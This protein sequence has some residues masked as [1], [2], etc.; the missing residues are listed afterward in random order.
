MS[1]KP[2][3]TPAADAPLQTWLRYLEQLHNKDIDLGLERVQRVCQAAGLQQPA[4]FVITVAGTN[5]KGSTVCYLSTILRNAGYRVGVYT[6]PHLERYNERVQINGEELSDAQHSQAFAAVEAVRGDTSLS[7]FEFGTLAAFWLMKQQPLDVAILEVGLG[8]RLDAVNTV[9]A[10]VAIVTSI[11]VD[12]IQFLGD[13]REL[14]GREKAGV[15]RPSKPLICGDPQPPKSIADSAASI[16]AKLYQVGQDFSFSVTPK[17][18]SYRGVESNLLELPLPQL[19]L[20]NAATAIAALEQLPLAVSADAI[21]Q[22]LQAA[23]LEGRMQQASYQNQSILLD[24]A[25]NEHAARYLAKQLH[26][27]YKNRPVYAVVGMLSDK[28][29]NAVFSTLKSQI[30]EWF[31]GSLSEPRGSQAEQLAAATALQEQSVTTFKSVEEAFRAALQRA[32][33][34]DSEKPL[35]FVFGSFYT[36]GR[37]NQLIRS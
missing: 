5:G 7:Y 33:K 26:S 17:G 35:V 18:W 19:P 32:Q 11:G 24:V 36:V 1:D 9:D 6:S 20:M 23:Q 8:G 25:H 31:L 4:R 22:G 10:D 15:A 12:H 37:V 14:I 30:S 13:N 2:L 34:N 28:D 3:A 16:G 27:R 21:E 29:H